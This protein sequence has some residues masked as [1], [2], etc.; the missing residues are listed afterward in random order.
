[1]RGPPHPQSALSQSMCGNGWTSE[2]HGG[3]SP[4]GDPGA[5]SLSDV[6]PLLEQTRAFHGPHNAAPA[7]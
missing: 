6:V 3:A 5:A 7:L 2:D 1:M 4:T